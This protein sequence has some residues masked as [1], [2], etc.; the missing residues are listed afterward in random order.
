MKN[1]AHSK[2]VQVI[3]GIP[4]QALPEEPRLSYFPFR[5][6]SFNPFTEELNIPDYDAG[7]YAIALAMHAGCRDILLAG[8][9]GHTDQDLQL[10]KEALFQQIM[11]VADR[12]QVT[13]SHITPTNYQ[14]F[15]HKSLYTV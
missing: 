3:T 1:G 9:D 2:K 6:G 13:I 10:A 5:I 4:V 11:E 12:H 15:N 14:A 7:I 8:F